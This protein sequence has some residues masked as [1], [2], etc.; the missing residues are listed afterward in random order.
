MRKQEGEKVVRPAG[1]EPA[2]PCSGG[3]CSIQLSYGRATTYEDC[4]FCGAETGPP[5]S[6]RS[7]SRSYFNE[8][9]IAVPDTSALWSCL[10]GSIQKTSPLANVLSTSSSPSR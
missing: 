6:Q 7:S 2:T 1:F 5:E 3:R 9:S 4:S 8:M 10:M